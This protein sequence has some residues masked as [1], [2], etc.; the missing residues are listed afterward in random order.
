MAR[1]S[2]EI[3]VRMAFDAR[4][5]QAVRLMMRD[6]AVPIA[7]GTLAGLGGAALATRVIASFLFET[8]PIEPATFAAVALALAG[9]GCL[10]ALIPALRA[11][12]VDPASTLRA[13]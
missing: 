10:A 4:P 2:A 3:G 11:A 9:T 5:G 6:S 8:K 7:I 13:E 12:R 1:R